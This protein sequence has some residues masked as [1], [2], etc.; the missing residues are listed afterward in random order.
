MTTVILVVGLPADALVP[1]TVRVARELDGW[2]KA[3]DELGRQ[4]QVR[5]EAREP[6]PPSGWLENMN[7]RSLHVRGAPI[8]LVLGFASLPGAQAADRC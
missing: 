5:R 8:G 3:V 7:P 4:G 6:T 1:R 2:A